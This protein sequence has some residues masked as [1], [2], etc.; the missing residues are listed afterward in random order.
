MNGLLYTIL[1]LQTS[2]TVDPNLNVTSLFEGETYD[3]GN[4]SWPYEA[5]K[6]KPFDYKSVAKDA[7]HNRLF[8][9]TRHLTVSSCL[10]GE[11]SDER[12]LRKV[13][14][15]LLAINSVTTEEEQRSNSYRDL[16]YSKVFQ[17]IDSR[18]LVSITMASSQPKFMLMT[19]NVPIHFFVAVGEYST[20]LIWTNEVDLQRRFKE[21]FNKAFFFYRLPTYTN[22][23]F[24]L[25]SN[26]LAKRYWHWC[27][28]M[29]DRLRVMNIL[30]EHLDRRWVTPQTMPVN[31]SSETDH[32]VA[33]N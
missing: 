10:I 33:P 15:N 6:P 24:V 3:E 4:H 12:L 17:R 14:Q 26:F 22:G 2:S 18:S 23:V 19:N 13:V 27:R 28:V 30:E 1:T 25:H 5:D 9:P 7:A 20:Y 16:A 8:V 31:E 29:R 32:L 11:T 21:K